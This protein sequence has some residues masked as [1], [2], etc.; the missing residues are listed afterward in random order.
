MHSKDAILQLTT[1]WNAAH[2]TSTSATSFEQ[3]A[4]SFKNNGGKVA[5]IMKDILWTNNLNLVEVIPMM[6]LKFTVNEI[7]VPVGREVALLLYRPSNLASVNGHA[8]GYTAQMFMCKPHTIKTFLTLELHR[9]ERGATC[10]ACFTPRERHHETT[11]QES[12]W[13]YM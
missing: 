10:P 8:N 11:E 1:S 7:T 5:L 4:C 3:S 2:M 12:V 6:N 13:A 9:G